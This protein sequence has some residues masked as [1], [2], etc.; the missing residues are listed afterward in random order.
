MPNS[1]PVALTT[2]LTKAQEAAVINLIRRTAR[3][4]IIPLFQNH[5]VQDVTRKSGRFD[6]VTQAD[7]AAEAMLRR[8]LQQMF[9][10]AL[11]IGEESA[12][13][14]S[15]VRA[16]IAEAE[17]CILLDPLDGTWNF[18]NDLPL[19]G[20]ILSITRYGVPI[21][22]L[23]YDPVRDDWI[24]AST[25]HGARKVRQ[26][27]TPRPLRMGS[28]ETPGNMSGFIHLHL[29]PQDLQEAIAPHLPQFA[30]TQV[31]NC[32]CHEYRTLAQGGADFCLSAM[33]TPWDH[34][35]GIVACQEAGGIARMLDGTDY[36]AG[37]TEGFLLTTN[38][39]TAWSALQER[40]AFLMDL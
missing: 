27:G 23:L 28:E 1:L 40:F 8:G 24:I 17:F 25:G 22:G 6:L 18:S 21:F 26:S 4:E 11:I 38:S 14:H 30:R 13:E 12:S 7:L 31:L 3:T 16:Q 19:F 5:G 29:M 9:P 35:A 33:M 39:E 10:H 20:V 36:N 32:S 37:I 15:E 34:A 2:P